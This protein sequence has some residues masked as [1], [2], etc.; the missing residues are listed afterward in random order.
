MIAVDTNLIVHLFVE[1]GSSP[2]ARQVLLRDADWTS[3]VLWRS[4]F[5]S[6]LVKCFRA[7]SVQMGNAHR[8]MT[9]ALK[10]MSGREYHVASGDVLELAAEARCSAY[11]AEFVSLARELEVPLIT[12]DKELL[13]K[14]PDTAVSPERYLAGL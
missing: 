1:S 13:E 3:P 12:T 9:A 7:G 14:F 2:L 5:R 11:D 8:I 10:M 6:A 4:E